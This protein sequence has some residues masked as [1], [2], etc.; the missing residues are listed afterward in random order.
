MEEKVL[1]GRGRQIIEISPETWKKHLEQLTEHGDERPGFMT[2]LHQRV[3][4]F[5]VSELA[6]TGKALLPEYI[7]ERLRMPLE[8]VTAILDE[9]E[10]KLFY[11]AR[12]E[13]G[14]V[15]WAYPVTVEPTPH[16]LNFSTGEQLY[17]A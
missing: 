17:A 6:R 2:E 9:L 14:A 10:K 12:D 8:Q 5:A 13:Q 1:L 11:L 16:R 4:Y 3:R 7:S 15:A